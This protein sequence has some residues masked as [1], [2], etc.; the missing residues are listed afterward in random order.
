MAGVVF[1]VATGCGSG[2]NEGGGGETGDAPAGTLTIYSG[3]EE[4]FVAPLFEAFEADTGVELDVRY[5]DS[6][7]LAATILE[8]GDG[9]PADV[10]FSQDAGSLG[11]VAEAGL[12]APIDAEVL[13]RVETR[14]RAADGL[15]VGTSGRGRVAVYNTETVDPAELPTSI[16]GFSEPEWEGRIGLPPT[17]SSFQ[18]HVA[19]M[20][21]A[22]GEDQTEEWLQGLVDNGVRVYED[23]GSTTRAVAAG[24]IEVGLVNHYYKYEVEAEDGTLPI[25]NHYFAEGDPGAFINVAGVGILATA[26]NADAAEAFVSYLTGEPGQTFVAEQTW[27]YPVVAGFE[28]SVDL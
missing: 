13:D 24:E 5:G 12:F 14:F 7:E 10:F 19:A 15:W 11:A 28:P 4:E 2:A 23:N 25:A 3:R 1:L 9:S 22:I 21:L 20:M 8:E 18:A 17:N 27:E 6:A 26:P 16:L